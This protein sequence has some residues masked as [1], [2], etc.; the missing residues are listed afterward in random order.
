MNVLVTGGSGVV[1]GPLLE[2]LD[3]SHHVVALWRK[4]LVSH[5][6]EAVR[7]DVRS[8]FL[9]LDA[10]TYERLCREVDVV[11]HSAAETSFSRRA[12]HLGVNV[13]GTR[14]VLRFAEDAGAAVVCLSTA[15]VEAGIS[16]VAEPSGYEESKRRCEELLASASVPVVAVRPSIVV[17]DSRTGEIAEMQGL[18]KVM[19]A[20][21]LGKMPVAPGG[22][23]G[24]VD[25][26][27]GDWLAKV[28]ARLAGSPPEAWPRVLWA[29]QGRAAM[30][31]WEFLAA[32]QQFAT[33]CGRTT[34][35]VSF[36]PYERI[37]RLFLPVFLP[38]LPRRRR[39]ELM[40]LLT[41]ARYLNIDRVF[42][43]VVDDPAL[44]T[45]LEVP[46]APPPAAVL[47][48]NLRVV[49]ASL[50]KDEEVLAG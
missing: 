35:P 38:E 8:E 41:F 20:I 31:N 24:F 50:A 29:T 22:P 9:G 10:P 15:F 27:P 49:W 14:R 44:S 34:E 25:F 19:A 43:S 7:G 18:H 23:L 5:C 13:E 3:A 36:M 37:V 28:V 17:G 30:R 33:T 2:E 21:L 45:L 42:P 1:G 47:A 12:D 39:L 6:A 16:S 26:V 32:V 46:S 4:R 48:A 40:S 11:V